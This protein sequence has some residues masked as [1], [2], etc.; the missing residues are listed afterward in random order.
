MPP[1]GAYTGEITAPMLTELAVA[2]VT[3][4]HSELRRLFAVTGGAVRRK[5]P[6]ALAVGLRPVLCVGETADERERGD[7]YR[8][9][10]QQMQHDLADVQAERLADVGVV[11]EPI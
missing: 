5:V 4:G 2:A 11:S 3:L 8:R 7:T 9:L 1:F 6:A 10:G